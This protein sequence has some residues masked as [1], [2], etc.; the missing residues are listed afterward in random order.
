MCAFHLKT[1]TKE[2]DFQALFPRL[3]PHPSFQLFTIVHSFLGLYILC[4]VC[5]APQLSFL[6][7]LYLFFAFI[8]ECSQNFQTQL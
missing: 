1:P 8:K 3:T 4:L 7:A 2:I 6:K 5:V